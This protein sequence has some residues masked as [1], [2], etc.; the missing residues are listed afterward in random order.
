MTIKKVPN[1]EY[2]ELEKAVFSARTNVARATA[3]HAA[4]QSFLFK[5]CKEKENA[6]I[7]LNKITDKLDDA[8]SVCNDSESLLS[9]TRET[10]TELNTILKETPKYIQ[11][12]D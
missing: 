4:K 8:F 1:P 10:L 3:Q 7:A 12:D 5:L 6:E 9:G 11:G 2:K